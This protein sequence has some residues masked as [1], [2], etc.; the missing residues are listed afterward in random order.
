M[1]WQRDMLEETCDNDVIGGELVV[2]LGL[3]VLNRATPPARIF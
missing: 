2:A 3:A 1:A